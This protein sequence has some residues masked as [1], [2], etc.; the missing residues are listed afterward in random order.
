MGAIAANVVAL[1]LTSIANT[2]A[3]RRLT[4]G[5]RGR[6]GAAR[7]QFQGLIIFGL[8][9]ALTTGALALLGHLAPPRAG[10]SSWP[11]SSPPTP[12]PPCCASSS[13]A[14]GSS[15]RAPHRLGDPSDPG[16]PG[17]T[18]TLS[19]S[20]PDPA[21]PT[22]V[23]TA[24]APLRPRWELPSLAVLLLGTA[25]FYLWNLSA[26]GWANTFYAAAVQAG[27]QNWTA[28]FFGSLDSANAITVD[29][30]PASLWVM[31]LS[32]RIFGFSSWSMLAPQAL[33]A[34]GAVALLW[35]T[36][37]RVAGPA[38]EPDPPRQKL[39][40]QA[41][42]DARKKAYLAKLS[43]GYDAAMK[44]AEAY[45]LVEEPLG[46]AFFGSTP[47]GIGDELATRVINGLT[48]LLS[49]FHL[50]PK[51]KGCIDKRREAFMAV[52]WIGRWAKR[53]RLG[54]WYSKAP[55]PAQRS[56]RW[57]R[58]V[59]PASPRILRRREWQAF[60]PMKHLDP[61]PGD[62]GVRDSSLS[63][64]AV[65]GFEFGFS[66]A[67]PNTLV[68]WEAQFGDFVNGAQI[69]IDQF[70]SSA[71]TKW[72]QP[73][74]LVLLLPHGFE[75]QGPEHSSARIER[76][77]QLCAENNMQVGN[78]TTPAQYFHVLRRQMRGGPEGK[79]IR[80]PLVLFTP[81]SLLRN[82]NAVSTMD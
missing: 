51:L 58:H 15:A 5:V 57:T 71:E 40:S 18:A 1:L 17:M 8:G 27:T 66:L 7:H 79:P 65:M 24:A 4:F 9:L 21:A 44:N 76:F 52:R 33:M 74:G 70:L 59:Q 11:S 61:E 36:V 43:D 81:K 73:C 25:A 80:K 20:A 78:C 47:T 35:A 32:G 19:A 6:D 42:L 41:D 22:P 75:G 48:S 26:S 28:F 31:A 30:P 3:N 16:E 2:A 60:V 54:A 39:L 68:I 56:G 13:S 10:P 50:H 55:G 34:V 37:R 49:D 23:P 72:G 69:I 12:P 82:A 53:S 29:K 67:E 64:F 45:E 63:E 14:P 46:P 77:L 38:A 62:F